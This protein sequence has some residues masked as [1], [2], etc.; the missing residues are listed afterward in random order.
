MG[1]L[2]A[3]DAGVKG[4]LGG[5]EVGG[6]FCRAEFFCE[7]A[8][9]DSEVGEDTV[10]GDFFG[11]VA[12]FGS[13]DEFFCVTGADVGEFFCDP[14]EECFQFVK[15]DA[16]D[17]LYGADDGVVWVGDAVGFDG[18]DCAAGDA[19]GVCGEGFTGFGKA[20]VPECFFVGVAGGRA[21]VLYCGEYGGGGWVLGGHGIV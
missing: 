7:V 12:E 10:A 14:G 11:E 8:D 13:A 21:G 6:K 3:D 4:F 9:V 15:V 5:D 18:V 20:G 2:P 17:G 19:A 1:V 16:G